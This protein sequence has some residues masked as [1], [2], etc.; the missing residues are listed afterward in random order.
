M[1]CV[2]ESKIKDRV[3]QTAMNHGCSDG[4][5][6]GYVCLLV[7]L[8]RSLVVLNVWRLPKLTQN[9]RNFFFYEK[10]LKK[11]KSCQ[12]KLLVRCCFPWNSGF[13]QRLS[14]LHKKSCVGKLP[15]IT[16]SLCNQ[17][18]R[19][20]FGSKITIVSSHTNHHQI[21]SLY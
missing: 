8:T 5:P 21:C 12:R 1:E 10:K 7:R 4:I 19:K 9:S 18:K 20:H 15:G 2:T 3:N 14:T 17:R 16:S 6:L 13:I 11:K